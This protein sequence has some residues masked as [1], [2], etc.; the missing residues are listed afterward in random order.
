MV[1][2]RIQD[3]VN[4]RIKVIRPLKD[5]HTDLA[6]VLFGTVR[7]THRCRGDGAGQLCVCAQHGVRL[8]RSGGTQ[9]PD[10]GRQLCPGVVLQDVCFPLTGTLIHL[11]KINVLSYRK[12]W[13]RF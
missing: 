6:A 4:L 9:L 13:F 7:A 1:R 12:L 5:L 2:F 8:S 11:Q 10:A 3:K